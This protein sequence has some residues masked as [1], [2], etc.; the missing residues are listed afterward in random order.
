MGR[1]AMLVHD[2]PRRV[3][4]AANREWLGATIPHG[5][6]GA[7]MLLNGHTPFYVGRSDTCLLTRLRG[8]PW[9]PDAS[10][11]VWE[12]CATAE[13]AFHQEAAWFHI[14]GA[15]GVF[16]NRVH[17]ARPTAYTKDC[18]FC[19]TRDEEALGYML[20]HFA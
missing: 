13:Q 4:V 11:V 9:L 16:R 18:P 20:P 15:G 14:L 12:P 2:E 6:V 19:D 1:R 5:V 8:H 10:H 7:Y 17:P 3:A